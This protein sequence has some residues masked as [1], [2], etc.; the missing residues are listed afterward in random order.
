MWLRCP[1]GKVAYADDSL[2]YVAKE[3]VG[4]AE[5]FIKVLIYVKRTLRREQCSPNLEA[6]LQHFG[7][8]TYTLTA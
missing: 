5:M 1:A 3:G 8:Q 7:F 4:R 6:L 2:P